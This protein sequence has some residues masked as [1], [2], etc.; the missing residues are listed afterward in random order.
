M[1]DGLLL[2]KLIQKLDPE[3]IF[4]KAVNKYV[5]GEMNIFK[6]QGNVNLA[7]N[8]LKGKI[9]MSGINDTGFLEL[10]PTPILSV[11]T[12]VCKLLAIKSINLN[13]CNE[14]WRLKEGDETL[15]DVLKL[16]PEEILI[17]WVNFHCHEAGHDELK[18]K[19]LGK[20]IAD[21]KAMTVVLNQ[22]D[23]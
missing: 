13:E 8:A 6:I 11:L 4:E 5:K 15:Q 23:K 20:D 1:S 12:Q 18:I 22:L 2:I 17:R 21:S 19:N 9:K 7:L 14:I 16:K 3:A 10:K